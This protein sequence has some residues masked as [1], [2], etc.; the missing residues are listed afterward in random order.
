MKM[1]FAAACLVLISLSAPARSHFI[2]GSDDRLP[3]TP[4]QEYLF[5]TVGLV[6]QAGVPAATGTV[7]AGGHLVLTNAHVFYAAGK[8]RAENFAFR[9][10]GDSI[11]VKEIWVGST[12]PETD[13]PHQDWAI[14]LLHRPAPIAGM[15]ELLG[16]AMAQAHADPGAVI[17]V[18][19]HKDRRRGEQKL[20]AGCSLFPRERGDLVATHWFQAEGAGLLL[21]D[22]DTRAMASGSPLLIEQGGIYRL[23]AIHSCHVNGTG[24]RDGNAFDPQRN[25]SVAIKFEGQFR[26]TF[27]RIQNAVLGAPVHGSD[28]THPMMVSFGN[29]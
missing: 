17:N 13:G 18:A 7:A 24:V 20:V 10:H 6:L 9:L 1:F 3:L 5:S 16:P 21:H 22:C 27:Y 19:F 4:G 23:V 8:P 14:A 11:A 15:V 12:S 28:L 2:Y 29:R 26:D 25:A